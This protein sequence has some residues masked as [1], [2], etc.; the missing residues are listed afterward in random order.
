MSREL[1]TL[2]WLQVLA[3]VEWP[4]L[5]RLIGM[6]QIPR[7]WDGRPTV[8]VRWCCSRGFIGHGCPRERCG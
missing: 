7:M 1:K 4:K 6:V 2:G 5:E 8:C 3:E